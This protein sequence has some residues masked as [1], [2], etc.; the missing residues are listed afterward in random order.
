MTEKCYGGRR[1]AYAV[2]ERNRSGRGRV[3]VF[4]FHE[5]KEVR[6]DLASSDPSQLLKRYESF[7]RSNTR[8]QKWLADVMRDYW[9]HFE[10]DLLDFEFVVFKAGEGVP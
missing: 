6:R 8:A 1:L 9:S 7:S 10:K 5:N 2:T 4:V 3:Q